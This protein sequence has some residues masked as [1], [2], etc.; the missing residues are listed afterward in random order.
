MYALQ[1]TPILSKLRIDD[2]P[3]RGISLRRRICF[4]FPVRSVEPILYLHFAGL[5]GKILD[6]PKTHQGNSDHQE[7]L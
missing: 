7:P 3:L 4:S 2:L 6:K 1:L 5:L